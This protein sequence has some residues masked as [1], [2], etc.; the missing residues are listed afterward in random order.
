MGGEAE[1]NEN[2]ELHL[3][4]LV[5]KPQIFYGICFEYAIITL[6]F[7]NC[8]LKRKLKTTFQRVRGGGGR[9]GHAAEQVFGWHNLYLS[10]RQI[11]LA[12][13]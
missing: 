13:I 6:K 8:W 5:Q 4:A 2:S 3:V 12:A 1:E 9:Q 7:L 10:K 11:K